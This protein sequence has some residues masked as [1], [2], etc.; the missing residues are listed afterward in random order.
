MGETVTHVAS[1][2]EEQVMALQ[3]W[4]SDFQLLNCF[5]QRLEPEAAA[6]KNPKFGDTCRLSNWRKN[7]STDADF[8]ADSRRKDALL[9]G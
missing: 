8:H 7:G 1:P 3:E 5:V 2:S 6:H 9:K 4:N